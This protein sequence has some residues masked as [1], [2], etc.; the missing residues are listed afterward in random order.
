MVDSESAV[1]SAKVVNG[2]DFTIALR[3]NGTVWGFGTINNETC[4]EEIEFPEE[5]IDITSGTT[6]ILALGKSGVVYAIGGNGNGQLG[7]GNTSTIKS[8]IKLGI[9]HIAKVRAIENTSY[10]ITEEGHVYEWG[11]GYTKTPV[12]NDYLENI[13]DIGRSYYLRTDGLVRCIKDNSII[14]LSI[15]E[16]DPSLPP[17]FVEEKVMQISEG[18]DHV[19]MLGESGRIYSYGKNTYGQ[20]GDRKYSISRK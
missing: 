10:A 7:I 12:L 13:T 15:N 4:P 5:I 6:H 8:P 1:A 11:E 19:L 2:K 9:D 14:R 20:L 16:Y 17:V 3:S 18:K